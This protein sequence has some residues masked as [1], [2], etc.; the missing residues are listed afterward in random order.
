VDD[1]KDSRTNNYADAGCITRDDVKES[2]AVC[3]HTYANA[4]RVRWD[5]VKEEVG[6]F[7]KSWY[8]NTHGV[9][10]ASNAEDM[11]VILEAYWLL[12]AKRY[13]QK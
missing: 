10:S 11:S 8:R 5:D 7:M 1:V 6:V 9:N 4:G 13:G 3:T 12:A 2:R